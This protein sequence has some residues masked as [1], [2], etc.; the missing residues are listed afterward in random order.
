MTSARAASICDIVL[1]LGWPSSQC[2]NSPA[3]DLSTYVST[4]QRRF[5]TTLLAIARA[6]SPRERLP[7][8]KMILGKLDL[9]CVAIAFAFGCSSRRS[10]AGS[11]ALGTAVPA[12][13]GPANDRSE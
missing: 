7:L 3:A 12:S 5:L 9:R 6:W 8:V 11:D 13:Q 1:T 2:C 4:I 10:M